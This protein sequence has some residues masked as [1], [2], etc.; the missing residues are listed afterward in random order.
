MSSGRQ[1]SLGPSNFQRVRV[2]AKLGEERAS[3][4]ASAIRRTRE[5]RQP[6]TR[7][8]AGESAVGP[9]TITWGMGR[10]STF[11]S[12]NVIRTGLLAEAYCPP[13]CTSVSSSR[14]TARLTALLPRLAEKQ[15]KNPNSEL[16]ITTQR[17]ASWQPPAGHA[18]RC[19]TPVF[20]FTLF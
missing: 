15:K 4:R 18:G 20:L 3:E 5:V 1:T 2:S 17:T 7:P 12:R 6:K 8:A 14:G 10:D 19:L 9:C 11:G 13:Y 16:Q